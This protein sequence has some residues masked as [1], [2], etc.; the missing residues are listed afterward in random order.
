MKN[1]Y[2][3]LL[4]VSLTISCTPEQKTE[5][6]TVSSEDLHGSVDKVTEIMIH[7]IFSPPVKTVVTFSKAA[8]LRFTT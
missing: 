2:F 7:D 8:N 4:M 1:I 3:I 6:I 5:P